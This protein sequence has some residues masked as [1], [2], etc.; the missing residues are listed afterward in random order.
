MNFKYFNFPIYKDS[1]DN[2]QTL[3][4]NS[5]SNFHV[6]VRAEDWNE[7]NQDLLKKILGAIELDIKKELE[8]YILKEGQ[9]IHL[10]GQLNRNQDHKYL[11]FGINLSRIGLQVKTTVYKILEIG[12]IKILVAH[13]LTELEKNISFKKQLWAELKALKS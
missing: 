6:F 9:E 10:S 3:L 12:F 11:V 5:N 1:T 2:I 4:N 13:S 7:T 8:I